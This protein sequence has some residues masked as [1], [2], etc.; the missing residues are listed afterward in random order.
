MRFIILF[1]LI[2]LRFQY[3]DCRSKYNDVNLNAI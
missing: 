1:N 3:V 2:Q